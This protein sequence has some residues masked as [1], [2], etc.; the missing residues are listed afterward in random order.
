MWNSDRCGTSSLLP[1]TSSSV[2]RRRLGVAQS[3]VSEQVRILEDSLG[4]ELLLRSSR[5]LRLT[6]AG[7][8]FLTGRR[9]L[10]ADIDR[11]DEV[12]RK[13]AQGQ[14]GQ[15][16]IGAVGPALH[17]AVPLILRRLIR[18]SAELEVSIHT[19]STQNQIQGLLSGDLD[20]G[21]FGGRARRCHRCRRSHPGGIFAHAQRSR[22]PGHGRGVSPSAP[23]S[24]LSVGN[25]L[26]EPPSTWI[27]T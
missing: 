17:R 1:K 7:E 9:K 5:P 10:L 14:S 4:A 23:A 12:V 20:A 6:P 21:L 13:H 19:M 3:T 24:S 18:A 22:F 15:L 11:L 25:S 16:R 8:V 26:S 2:K 27:T